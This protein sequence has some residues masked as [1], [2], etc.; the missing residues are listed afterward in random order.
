MSHDWHVAEASEASLC[1]L[2]ERLALKLAAGD[3]IALSGELGAGKTTF[4]RALIRALLGDAEA[5]VPS[6]TFSL[7]QTYDTPRLT[8]AHLDLY[9]LSGEDETAELGIEDIVRSGALLV[10]WPE[11]APGVLGPDRLD[12]RLAMGSTGE[13]RNIH[14][15]A[16]GTWEARLKRIEGIS[17]FLSREPQWREAHVRYLQGD[18]SARGYAR[19][20]PASPPP[21]WGRPGGGD[22]KTLDVGIPP[23]LNPSP[24]GGG[25]CHAVLMDFPRQPDGPPIRDGLPYSRIAHLA[26]DVRPFVA[27]TGILKD[28]GLSAP[29]IYASDL[30]S[31]LLLLED[32][33]DRIFGREVASGASQAELWRAAVDALLVLSAVPVPDGI[34][35]A[36]GTTYRL[37]AQDKGVL[38]IETELVPDWYWPAVKGSTISDDARAEF[39]SVWDGIF[40][41]LVAMPRGWSLRDFHSPNLM[42]LP[43]RQGPARAGLLD[44]QDALYGPLAYDLVSLLQ[45]ARVD[46]PQ[47][48]ESA[49]YSEYCRARRGADPGFDGEAFSFAYAALGAQRSTKIL[50]IFARLAKRD[51]K[52]HYLQHIPRIWRYVERSLAHPELGAL[53]AWY[54]RHLPPDIRAAVPVV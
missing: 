23:T 18:A 40:D 17:D 33:G 24:Q 44:F 32:F 53:R 39:S 5:E 8:L 28:A 2:A 25:E 19:L 14:M 36:D 13:T 20:I 45:D 16:S 47:E 41:R 12:I 42:W 43:D 21:L 7:V 29:A 26:E 22:S 9:R 10:E 30:D 38:A 51:A 35:L 3:T 34:P 27:I 1:R 52:P 46:V 4:A 11:R 37:P 48:L 49:L 6:P 50:G 31:G 15:R 54:D